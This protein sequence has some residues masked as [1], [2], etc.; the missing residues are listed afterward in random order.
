MVINIDDGYFIKNIRIFFIYLSEMFFVGTTNDNS[1][2]KFELRGDERKV[3]RINRSV[4]RCEIHAHFITY[5]FCPYVENFVACCIERQH[6][7]TRPGDGRENIVWLY[8][9]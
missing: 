1:Q 4:F 9:K 2:V 8:K 7:V 3:T 6:K 5:G